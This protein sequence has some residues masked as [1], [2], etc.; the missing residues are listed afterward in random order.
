MSDRWIEWAPRMGRPIKGPS[1]SLAAIRLR[2][3]TELSPLP[4]TTAWTPIGSRADI[5]AYLPAN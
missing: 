5:V 2:D 4:R 3:G 1:G